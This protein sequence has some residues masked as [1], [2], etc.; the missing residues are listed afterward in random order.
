[1]ITNLSLSLS[2]SRRCWK[3]SNFKKR[4]VMTHLKLN[5]LGPS[6]FPSSCITINDTMKNNGNKSN[7]F[8]HIPLFVCQIICRFGHS[9]SHLLL[10]LKSNFFPRFSSLPRR[11]ATLGTRLVNDSPIYA[12]SKVSVFMYPKT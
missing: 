7:A 6:R 4:E 5:L 1:M 12:F 8:P 11:D 10:Q 2:N 9:Y 3:R